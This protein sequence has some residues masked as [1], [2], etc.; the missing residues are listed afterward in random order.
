MHMQVFFGIV[1]ICTQVSMLLTVATK[2][3]RFPL[4]KLCRLCIG[5]TSVQAAVARRLPTPEHHPGREGDFGAILWVSRA[6]TPCNYELDDRNEPGRE[7]PRHKEHQ[8]V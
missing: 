7:T 4:C 8:D 6:Q 3:K 2:A 5:V 1:G